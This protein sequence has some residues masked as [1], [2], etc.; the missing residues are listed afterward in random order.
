MPTVIQAIT[1]YIA[2]LLLPCAAMVAA[3]IVLHL[4]SYR[5]KK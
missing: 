4:V 2:I 3:A 1:F 5:S